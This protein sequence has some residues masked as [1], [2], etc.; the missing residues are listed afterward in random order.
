MKKE[1]IIINDSDQSSLSGLKTVTMNSLLEEAKVYYAGT[2]Y[3]DLLK[4]IPKPVEKV[5][6]DG[7]VLMNGLTYSDVDVL[8]SHYD[9][10]LRFIDA[11][12]KRQVDKMIGWTKK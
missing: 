10:I 7:S 3:G 1:Q 6:K 5:L 12:I 9:T 11:D 2:G 4:L 8:L